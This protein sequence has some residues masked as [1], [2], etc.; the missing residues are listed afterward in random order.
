M[1]DEAQVQEKALVEEAAIETKVAE[2]APVEAPGGG[3]VVPSDVEILAGSL[4]EDREQVDAAKVDVEKEDVDVE[5]GSLRRTPRSRKQVER[6]QVEPI[7][8]KEEWK[9]PVG[10]GHRLLDIENVAYLVGKLQRKDELLKVMHNL[11]YRRPASYKIIK[12]NVLE[13]SG[14]AYPP[15]TKQ[16]EREKDVAKLEAKTIPQLDEILG[17]LDLP[18]GTGEGAYKVSKINRILDFLDSPQPT[19][20]RSLAVLEQKKKAKKA[21]TKKRS[22]TL[23]S[24][25]SGRK[26]VKAKAAGTPRK[27]AKVDKEKAPGDTE[28]TDS[29]EPLIPKK[30]EGPSD[31]TIKDAIAEILRTKDLSAFSMKDLYRELGDKLQFDARARKPFVK[32]TAMK[33]IQG[34]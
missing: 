1:A 8:A 3:T 4:D 21:T 32:E 34:T 10:P 27:K 2:E 7:Q 6:I 20:N 22:Q 12:N 33:I 17:L 9:V 29:D 14:F 15:G 16:T 11:M 30:P 31:A 18:R 28:S 26:A 23:A 25:T 24:P 13:F 19:G 5:G